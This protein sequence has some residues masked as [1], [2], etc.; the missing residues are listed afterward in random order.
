MKKNKVAL[1]ATAPLVVKFHLE[2]IIEKLK[3]DFD[4]VVLTNLSGQDENNFLGILPD[5]VRYIDTKMERKISLFRDVRAL[6]LLLRFFIKEDV[7]MVFT[8]SPKAFGDKV[9]TIPTSSLIKKRRSKKRALTSL[10]RE[11][12]R[13]IFVSI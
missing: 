10:K 8:L 3:I 7:G 2:P 11:I 13:S 6:F 9:K 5:G 4:V 12:L 1:I